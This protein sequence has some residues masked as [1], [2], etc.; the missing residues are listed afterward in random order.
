MAYFLF[1]ARIFFGCFSQPEICLG[2]QSKISLLATIFRSCSWPG[3][4]AELGAQSRL[5]GLPIGFMDAILRAPAMAG[6]L[7]AYVEPARLRRWTIARSELPLAIP[8][9]MSRVRPG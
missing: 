9:E 3:Q 2:D 4:Q 5:P 6:Y 1:G 8:R 7:S